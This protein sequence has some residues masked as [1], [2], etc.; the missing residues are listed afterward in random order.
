MAAAFGGV[1]FALASGAVPCAFARATHMPCPGCG[2]TRAVHALAAGDLREVVHMNAL[3]PILGAIALVLAVGS[4]LSVLRS[5]STAAFVDSRGGRLLARV[6][7]VVA[8]LEVVL[9]I[10]RFFGAFGGPV[11]V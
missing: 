2:S 10:A 7:I 1:G 6:A 4:T 5:G 8:I 9:W 3:G 11:S